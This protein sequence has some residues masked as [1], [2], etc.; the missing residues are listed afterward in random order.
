MGF[1]GDTESYM[2]Q[3]KLELLANLVYKYFGSESIIAMDD[4]YVYFSMTTKPRFSVINATM[5][6]GKVVRMKI[7]EANN[8]VLT[9][10]G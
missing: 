6:N 10:V 8:F 4:S 1:C 9:N 3:V 5:Y 7:S 2:I